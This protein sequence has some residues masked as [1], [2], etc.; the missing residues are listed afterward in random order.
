MAKAKRR[1]KPI[2]KTFKLV[3]E[4][5]LKK[6]PKRKPKCID[7]KPHKFQVPPPK[8]DQPYVVGRCKR[9]GIRWIF[10]SFVDGQIVWKGS[11]LGQDMEFHENTS[12]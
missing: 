11:Y 9:C 3:N 10:R 4:E 8:E 6:L 2:W 5:N 1:K 7:E 12:V